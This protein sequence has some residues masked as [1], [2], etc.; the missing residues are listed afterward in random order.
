M[1]I[2]KKHHYLP[3]F[4]MRRW[5]DADGMVTEYRRPRTELIVKRKHPAQT[6]YIVDLYAN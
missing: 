4:F 5:V 3:Q 1:S 2:P 6:G